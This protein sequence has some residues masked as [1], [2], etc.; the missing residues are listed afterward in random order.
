MTTPKRNEIRLKATELFNNENNH[1]VSITPTIN[2]LRE[3][4]YWRKAQLDLMTNTEKHAQLSYLEEMALEMGYR[5]TPENRFNGTET[6]VFHGLKFDMTEAQRSNILCTGANRSGKTLLSCSIASVLMRYGWRVTVFDSSGVWRT[7]SDVPYYY[8]VKPNEYYFQIPTIENE[9]LIYDLSSLIP[10]RQRLVVDGVLRTLWNNRTNYRYNLWNMIILEES[11]LYMKNM[12]GALSQNLF[13]LASVGRNRQIRL[14][15]ICFDL[16]LIDSAFARLCSQ[17][18][19]GKLNIESNCRRKFKAYYGKTW[20]DVA[21][22]LQTGS[23]IYVLNNN[24]QK[25]RI[26]QFQR[27]TLKPRDIET[28]NDKPS[29]ENGLLAKIRRAFK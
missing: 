24:L 22:H 17:R 15:A 1:L 20:L 12:R 23:F 18:F 26:P 3:G 14:M 5:L 16:A 8:E 13:R 7:V 11:Q 21:E 28:L 2:E 10:E 6:E 9:S 4:N 27:T 19:H 25:I 29:V